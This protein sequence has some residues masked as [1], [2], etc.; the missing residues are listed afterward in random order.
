MFD[1]N[2]SDCPYRACLECLWYRV[3]EGGLCLLQQKRKQ[4]ATD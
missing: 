3:C 4:G 2:N 1:C